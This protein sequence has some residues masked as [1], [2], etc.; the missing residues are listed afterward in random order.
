M[1]NILDL[2]SYEKVTITIKKKEYELKVPTLDE[3]EGFEKL[4]GKLGDSVEKPEDF[5]K[6]AK[7][8]FVKAPSEEVLGSLKLYQYSKLL[9]SVQKLVVGDSTVIDASKKK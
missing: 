7:D 8:L 4:M 3:L 5:K 1:T 6:F 2:D 9:E